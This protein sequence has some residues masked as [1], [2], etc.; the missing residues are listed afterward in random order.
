ML[1]KGTRFLTYSAVL[2]ALG[3]IMVLISTYTP[4]GRRVLLL[5][6]GVPVMIAGSKAGKRGSVSVYAITGMILLLVVHPIRGIAYLLVAGG[7]PLVINLLA[8]PL[9]VQISITA[10]LGFCYLTTAVKVM[11]LPIAEAF[12]KVTEMIPWLGFNSTVTGVIFLSVASL[13]Y[14][15]GLKFLLRQIERHWVYKHIFKP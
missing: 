12:T 4:I 7:V 14:V 8:V 1:L 3:I 11:G 13:L 6:S 10:L 9:L 5:L 15:E 2:I